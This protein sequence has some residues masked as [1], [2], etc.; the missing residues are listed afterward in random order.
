MAEPPIEIIRSAR[1]TRS[2]SARLRP[3][4][5]LLKHELHELPGLVRELLGD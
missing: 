2:V 4:G 5:V 1:R 3:D